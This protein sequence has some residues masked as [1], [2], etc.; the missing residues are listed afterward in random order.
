[1]PSR[2]CILNLMIKG[3]SLASDEQDAH[4]NFIFSQKYALGS[5]NGEELRCSYSDSVP[6]S[7]CMFYVTRNI[8]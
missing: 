6:I 2:L 7:A 5:H 4:F 3:L 1:M 8:Q